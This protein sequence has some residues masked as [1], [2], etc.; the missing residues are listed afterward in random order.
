MNL[1]R[2]KLAEPKINFAKMLTSESES[3]RMEWNRALDES[4]GQNSQKWHPKR[5]KETRTK[6]WQKQRLT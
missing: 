3:V 5:E 4:V 2:T 6:T 1:T